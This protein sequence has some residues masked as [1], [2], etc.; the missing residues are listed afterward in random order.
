MPMLTE[1]RIT[2]TPYNP[3]SHE[4]A[5]YAVELLDE[6]GYPYD[7]FMIDAKDYLHILRRM[8]EEKGYKLTKE[9]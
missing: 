3:G 4:T 7:T 2:F 8:A 5:F 1:V 6:A 9:K